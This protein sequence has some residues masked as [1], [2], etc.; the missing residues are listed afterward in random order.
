MNDANDAS[1]LGEVQQLKNINVEIKRL[2]GQLKNLREKKKM[3]ES[4]ILTYLDKTNKN[5]ATAKDILVLAREKTVNTRKNE[6]AKSA[7]ISAILAHAGV[8]NV[9]E[10]VSQVLGALKGE[11][12]TKKMLVVKQPV[13]KKK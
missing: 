11:E 6:K 13:A 4:N 7:D 9:Q 12:T 3:I 1:T 10:T 2:S 5:G 8:N